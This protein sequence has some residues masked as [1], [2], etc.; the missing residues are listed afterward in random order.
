MFETL[1]K[2]NIVIGLD[3]LNNYYDVKL[4]GKNFKLQEKAKKLNS[5]FV[6]IKVDL[7]NETEI[8]SIL[9]NIL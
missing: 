3:N 1:D 2:D 6:F 5:K 7:E 9:R 4:K 8:R